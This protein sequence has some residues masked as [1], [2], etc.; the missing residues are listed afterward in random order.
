MS[1]FQSREALE[2]SIFKEIEHEKIMI[3]AV[4][5]P[6]VENGVGPMLMRISP[7]IKTMLKNL[8][9]TGKIYRVKDNENGTTESILGDKIH[10]VT[11]DAHVV[12]FGGT[13][14]HIHKINDRSKFS[15]ILP[16][17][18]DVDV[19]VDLVIDVPFATTRILEP[20]HPLYIASLERLVKDLKNSSGEGVSIFNQENNILSFILR[21]MVETI[22][23]HIIQET[24]TERGISRDYGLFVNGRLNPVN[25]VSP[26]KPGKSRSNILYEEVVANFYRILVVVE[27]KMLKVQV[28]IRCRDRYKNVSSMD[29]VFEIV[30][31]A[32]DYNN[33]NHL[34]P[35][36]N[37]ENINGF[38]V[39]D[40]KKL[41]QDNL[42]S[43]I[44]RVSHA[45]HS[46]VE[47]LN[48]R[49]SSGKCA[50]DFLRVVYILLHGLQESRPRWVET[51]MHI[52]MS[53]VNDKF[54]GIVRDMVQNM[55]REGSPIE[56]FLFLSKYI[57]P[58]ISASQ[59]RNI[60]VFERS[61]EDT[62]TRS[63]GRDFRTIIQE[64]KKGFPNAK[65]L[66]EYEE[67]ME[68]ERMMVMSQKEFHD[69]M[70]RVNTDLFY[71]NRLSEQESKITFY[72]S[73]DFDI[74][75]DVHVDI[76]DDIFSGK[77]RLLSRDG[78]MSV[79]SPNFLGGDELRVVRHRQNPK[80][81]YEFVIHDN[82]SIPVTKIDFIKAFNI[83]YPDVTE[84][85]HDERFWYK[86]WL[87]N[88]KYG[89]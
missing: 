18:H 13:A 58:C 84:V 77:M 72:L 75:L 23:E 9:Y 44:N 40:K 5:N 27:E 49:Y 19:M 51:N 29:H 63:I 53:G 61:D 60:D 37:V 56:M 1:D 38:D 14:Y 83:K 52:W 34:Y 33:D 79:S 21:T 45:K 8:T 31:S 82:I 59:I 22:R 66:L 57:E 12:I 85:Q 25:L 16:G 69:K 28:E 30:M 76:P 87:K 2:V 88:T 55:G 15:H 71:M 10:D 48:G 42:I 65:E 70:N 20:E 39:Y 11:F 36:D 46:G 64:F 7:K 68:F 50:Q 41:F 26:Y 73:Q 86:A 54:Q 4:M 3:A 6:A 24:S 35:A 74:H 78:I 67:R 47:S 43:L 17:I 62:R 89:K 32:K 81:F 80:G